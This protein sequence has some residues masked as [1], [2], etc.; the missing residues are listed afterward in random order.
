MVIY[1]YI[2]LQTHVHVQNKYFSTEILKD[3][4]G[5]SED[6]YVRALKPRDKTGVLVARQK[7]L[8]TLA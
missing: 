5:E 7:I 1:K 6:H 3:T 4:R 8:T 2:C